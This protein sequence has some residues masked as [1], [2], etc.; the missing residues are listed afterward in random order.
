MVIILGSS[1]T[2][3]GVDDETKG[4]TV[5]VSVNVGVWVAVEVYVLTG[6]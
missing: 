6:V 5:C 2:M 4:V 3:V 1:D